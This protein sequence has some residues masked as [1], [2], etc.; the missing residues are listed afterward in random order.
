MGIHQ[1]ENRRR[2]RRKAIGYP[3]PS[4]S[5]ASIHMYTYRLLQDI[6]LTTS[7]PELVYYK[8][9]GLSAI[10][11]AIQ[12]LLFFF[13]GLLFPFPKYFIAL[14]GP[15]SV[16]ITFFLLKLKPFLGRKNSFNISFACQLSREVASVCS[17]VSLSSYFNGSQP[18]SQPVGR[19]VSF[20]AL[21]LLLLPNVSRPTSIFFSFSLP[22]C[23]LSIFFFQKKVFRG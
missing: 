19:S 5:V 1:R 9:A 7:W 6:H 2:W 16:T 21:H 22:S 8:P 15:F 23:L 17:S 10:Q 11:P 3:P 12:P 4:S 14:S 20:L 18:A 13:C